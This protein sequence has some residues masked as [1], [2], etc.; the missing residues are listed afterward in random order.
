[1]SNHTADGRQCQF[2]ICG[3][4][5][6]FPCHPSQ[7]EPSMKSSKGAAYW[8]GYVGAWVVIA[9]AVYALFVIGSKVLS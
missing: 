3:G 4:T 2:D 7:E 1:M 6:S 8:S 9:L 5:P